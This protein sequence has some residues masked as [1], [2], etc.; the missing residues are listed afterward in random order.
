ME[1]YNKNQMN[2]TVENQALSPSQQ[3]H[4]THPFVSL[5]HQL[6]E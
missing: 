5:H 1:Q 4:K 3:Q 2:Q 6:K